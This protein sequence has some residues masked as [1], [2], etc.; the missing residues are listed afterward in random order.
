MFFQN[1][2]VSVGIL[3]LSSRYAHAQLKVFSRSAQ[4]TFA[5][6]SRYA[7]AQLTVCSAQ[8]MLALDSRYAHAQLKVCSRS[9]QGMLMLSARYAPAQLRVFTLSAPVV[10]QQFLLLKTYFKSLTKERFGSNHI[11]SG[12]N[13]CR[14]LNTCISAQARSQLWMHTES[15]SSLTLA[16]KCSAS[17]CNKIMLKDG[18]NTICLFQITD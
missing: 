4:G 7:H 1:V 14:H 3:A 15:Q 9:A 10:F 13:T 5:L 16:V 18:Q 8:G 17:D 6:S 12:S 11:A 2:S